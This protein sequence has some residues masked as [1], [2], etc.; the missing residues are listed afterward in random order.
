M[1]SKG[2]HSRREHIIVINI[3]LF[4]NIN[5]TAFET[6][7]TL[8]LDKQI[9]ILLWTITDYPPF[10][11]MVPDRMRKCSLKNCFVTKNKLYYTDET[12]FDV[13]LFNVVDLRENI[14]LPQKRL[15][16]QKY[17]FVSR[18]PPALFTPPFQFNGYFNLTWTYKSISDI[19]LRYVIV[20]DSKGKI[21]GPNK[22]IQW[23]DINDM[24]P[25]NKK[26][27]RKLKH[28]QLAV[29]WIVSHCYTINKREVYVQAL[30]DELIK[31]HLNIDIFGYCSKTICADEEE[32]CHAKLEENYYFYLAFENSFCEEYVSEKLLTATKHFMVPIVYGGADYTRF[33]N[34][35]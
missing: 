15:E 14:S 25:I 24:K 26:I 3:L 20:K 23:M 8:S 9:N 28:K 30:Q 10:K 17:V 19:T 2:E 5:L 34:D 12:D 1:L 32:L 6:N 16:S 29:A 11:Y 13:V 4:L 7:N 18:E 22:N 27:K 31:Y 33:V 21:I 35:D